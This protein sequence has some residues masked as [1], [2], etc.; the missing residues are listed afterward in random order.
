M[1]LCSIG[2]GGPIRIS[3]EIHPAM[4]G[5]INRAC[6]QDRAQSLKSELSGVDEDAPNPLHPN[7]VRFDVSKPDLEI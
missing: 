1:L 5:P 6:L 7:M 4:I 3:C 2:D